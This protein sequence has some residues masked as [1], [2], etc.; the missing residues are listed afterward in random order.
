MRAD[1]A[2]Q[3]IA[4]NVIAMQSKSGSQKPDH[5]G[6]AMSIK[7]AEG[8]LLLE[9]LIAELGKHGGPETFGQGL[10]AACL[11]LQAIL[12][13]RREVGGELH[14]GTREY[15]RQQ[16]AIH[17]RACKAAGI[18][19]VPKS[20]LA[21]H[22]IDRCHGLFVKSIHTNTRYVFLVLKL[23]VTE[24]SVLKMD[25][26]HLIGASSKRIVFGVPP[27]QEFCPWPDDSLDL[28]QGWIGMVD[29][30]YTDA[31]LTRART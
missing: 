14:P 20:H 16:M 3:N 1:N 19:Y 31:G 8:A 12:D 30:S 26:I 9:F 25:C 28:T 4:Q 15:L 10:V 13:K 29:R 18:A 23:V 2:R 17:M 6:A 7:A 22:L 21:E 24:L 27:P 11:T 5:P